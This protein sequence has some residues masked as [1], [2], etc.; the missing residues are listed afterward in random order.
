[1]V[2]TWDISTGIHKAS[3]QTPTEGNIQRDVQLIDNRLILVY[4]FHKK[5]CVWDVGN[6]KQLLK[7]GVNWAG[8]VKISG[9]GSKIFGL[10]P[11]SIK[12]WSIQKGRVV[13]RGKTGLIQEGNSFIVDER[14]L[15]VDGSKI[16]AYRSRSGYEGWD[17]GTSWSTPTMLSGM[18]TLSNGSMLWDPRQGRIKNAAT[19]GVLFQLSGRF[20]NPAHVQCDGSYLVAGYESGEILILNLK[21][22]ML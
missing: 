6:E 1:M 11:R 3:F 2:K 16:W 8:A 9:D 4:F 14:F 7:V 12:A 21:D 5:I 20:A 15:I 17:F 13:G 19:G 22:I 10:C 18:P